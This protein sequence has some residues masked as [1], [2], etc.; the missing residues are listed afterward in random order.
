MV[1]TTD[2]S[3]SSEVHF[4]HG[5]PLSLKFIT[6]MQLSLKKDSHEPP[7]LISKNKYIKIKGK[8]KHKL[9]KCLIAIAKLPFLE[10]V[11]GEKNGGK[12]MCAH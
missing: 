12:S 4:P 5:L 8:Q 9:L 1:N 3:K 11:L 2:N 6:H 7:L 10:K